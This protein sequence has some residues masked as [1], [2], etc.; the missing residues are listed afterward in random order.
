MK[1]YSAKAA[2]IEKKWI[3]IDGDGLVVGRLATIV[4]MHLRGKH[5]PSYTPHMDDGD[6]V[7][8]INADKVVFTGKK[9]D[10]K[11]YYWHTGYPGGIKERTARKLIEGRFPERVVEKAVE[12]MLPSGP[13]GR[14]QLKN[15]RVYAGPEHPH[16]AQQPETLDVA[17]LSKKNVRVF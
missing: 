16:A 9:L 1:T 10:Q 5:K 11:K 3:V 8:V 14:Q 13:L 12:R 17:T 15:L 6:N 2:D 7:V 4:A